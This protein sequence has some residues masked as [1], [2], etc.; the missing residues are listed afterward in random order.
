[1]VAFLHQAVSALKSLSSAGAQPNS[2]R[3]RPLR[4]VHRSNRDKHHGELRSGNFDARASFA[5]RERASLQ[6]LDVR[7]IGAILSGVTELKPSRNGPRSVFT[8]Y[9][10]PSTNDRKEAQSWCTSVRPAPHVPEKSRGCRL[11]S[12]QFGLSEA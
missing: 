7:I 12:R 3:A 10:A 2:A 4:N 8:A 9:F 6:E 11:I 1:M 5:Q